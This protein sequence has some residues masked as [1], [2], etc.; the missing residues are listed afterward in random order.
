MN[1]T[2]Y[3]NSCPSQNTGNDTPTI[4]RIIAHRA[5]SDLGRT[6][7]AMP[8]GMPIASQRAAAPIPMIAETGSLRQ[9]SSR[10]GMKLENE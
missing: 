9:I 2:K 10:T 8:I 5:V 7:E 3:N 4:A 6:P 1:Q